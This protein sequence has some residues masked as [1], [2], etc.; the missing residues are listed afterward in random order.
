[1]V[2]D[3]SLGREGERRA[4]AFLRR[5]GYRI[6]GRNVRRR[7]GEID[8]VAF[9]PVSR[10]VCFVEVKARRAEGP[11][12]AW[13]AV[14][15]EKRRRIRTAAERFLAT[16][17]TDYRACRFDAVAAVLRPDGRWEIEHLENCF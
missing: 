5:R 10:T 16:V 11:A 2:A 1:M 13:E 8:L 14:T 15:P 9:E 4:E 7:V 17:R 3:P 6:L 12:S